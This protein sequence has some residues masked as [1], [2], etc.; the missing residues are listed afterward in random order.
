MANVTATGPV[1]SFTTAG[2]EPAPAAP[3][4]LTAIAAS[5]TQINL[6]WNDVANET[7]YRVERSPAAGGPWAEIAK[8]A[9][10]T[11]SYPS[12]GLNPQTDLFLSRARG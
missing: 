8:L 9:A 6:T 3:T 11:T 10:N 1:W 4:G 7:G 2:T 12:T 5:S